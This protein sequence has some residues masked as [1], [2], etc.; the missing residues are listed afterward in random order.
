M[1]LFGTAASAVAAEEYISGDYTY[2]VN[3][4]NAKITAY[5]ETATGAVEIPSTLGGYSVNEIGSYSFYAC[6]LISSVTIPDGVTKI[7]A[8]AFGFCTSL[9]SVTIPKSVTSIGNRAF[10]NCNNLTDVYYAGTEE[11]WTRITIDYNYNDVLVDVI[12]HFIS[13]SESD[14]DK[15][16]SRYELIS[17]SSADVKYTYK[18]SDSYFDSSAY[19]YS[20]N[21]MQLSM[22]FAVSAMVNDGGPYEDKEPGVAKK[23]FDD[24]KFENFTPYGYDI[25][26]ASEDD[27]SIACVIGSKNIGETTVIAIAV[28]GQGYEGEWG[29]NF[30]VGTDINHL[31]FNKASNFVLSYL[32]TFVASNKEKFNDNIKFWVTGYSRAAA[33]AN[34]V[35]AKLDEGCSSTY[36][37]IEE[38]N[39]SADG[40]YAYTFETPQNTT[41]SDADNLLYSNIFNIVNP[42][43]LVPRV[44]P[45]A[46]SFSRYGIDYFI[47]SAEKTGYGKNK[48][49]MENMYTQITSGDVYEENFVAAYLDIQPRKTLWDTVTYW[50]DVSIK[51]NKTLSQSAYLD[52]LI[53]VIA[54]DLL[55]SKNNYVHN[56]QSTVTKFMKKYPLNF[57]DLPNGSILWNNIKSQLDFG[58]LWTLIVNKGDVAKTLRPILATAISD[59]LSESGVTYNEAYDLLGIIDDAIE[60]VIN[61]IDTLISAF[62]NENAK[63]LFIPHEVPTTFSWVMACPDA[64]TRDSTY[65]KAKYNCPVDVNVYDING[66]LV[67][68]IIDDVPQYIEG[69]FIS[70]YVDNDGQKVFCLP[71]DEKFIFEVLGTDTGTM[72]C[73]FSEY[74]FALNTEFMIENYYEIP[75]DD[76]TEI[77]V[78]LSEYNSEA[79]EINVV[80]EENDDIIQSSETINS[81]AIETFEVNVETDSDI[82]V[83]IGGGEYIKGEYA[84]VTAYEREANSFI[85]WYINGELVSEDK[86]YRFM[87]TQSVDII[88]KF[89]PHTHTI[90]DTVILPTETEDGYTEHKCEVCGYLYKDNYVGKL[91][92]ENTTK[93]TEPTTK[94]VVTAT[95]EIRKPSQTEIKYGDSIILHADVEN[96]PA[97]ATIEWTA[98]NGNFTY[99][100]SA[101]GTTCTITPSATGTTEITA[102]VYDSEGREICS[103]S[104]MMSAKAGLWQKIVAFFKSIFGL[105]VVYTE[106]FKV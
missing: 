15:N 25:K 40:V 24:I 34:L 37:N 29:S 55:E 14:T 77:T 97:G 33:T 27:D 84:K 20:I 9:E 103:D 39:Y 59:W 90:T 81:D 51:E 70:A 74:D 42:I 78:T 104:V 79:G 50:Y 4:T 87:V 22:C 93:P 91:E 12:I 85:G 76:S 61:N 71:D 86:E 60:A 62:Y 13:V 73:S 96:L 58:D 21:L 3:G 43:D 92:S 47:P 18:Y 26:P 99:T 95:V 36:S 46:W 82:G 2:V 88:G 102:T 45:S 72:S 65:A 11:E 94:P 106:I 44:A 89:K 53:G 10:D 41:D 49:K 38:L 32:N 52:N 28:R 67:A 66:Q 56:Y 100:A 54:E 98:D 57:D 30:N 6:T 35:A 19:I 68:S 80:V 16:E 8:N 31:G 1:L 75:V 63:R 5:P 17:Y 23:F 64:I 7:G 101:D 83:A 69:S 48:E 105:T